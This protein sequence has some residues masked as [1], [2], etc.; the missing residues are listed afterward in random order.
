MPAM[1]GGGGKKGSISNQP[2][3][4]YAKMTSKR[5]VQPPRS[6]W[7]IHVPPPFRRDRCVHIQCLQT[8]LIRSKLI[9]CC[10]WKEKS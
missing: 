7:P 10:K 4:I 3:A 6:F 2:I 8:R 9:G 1:T 5:K